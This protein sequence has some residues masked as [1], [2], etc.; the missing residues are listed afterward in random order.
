M[1][2][3][4]AT[5]GLRESATLFGLSAS[6]ARIGYWICVAIALYHIAAS[7][8][9]PSRLGFF[10]STQIQSAI[11]LGSAVLVVFLIRFPYEKRSTINTIFSVVLAAAA[12]VSLGVVIFDYDRIL[13][14]SLFGTLDPTGVILALCLVIPL[15]EALRRRTGWIL[16]I[17]I[18]LLVGVV[19]FQP[20][21]PGALN[22]RG[23]GYDRL[24]Y[25]AYVGSQ[26]IFGMP[27]RVAA[28]I[29]L[30]FIV[31]GALISA[32]GA[33]KWFLDIA[34]RLT[35]H[36]VGGPAKSAVVASALFGSISGSPSANAASTGVLTIPLMIRAGY[37]PKFAAAT[38]A[39]A[40]TSGQI[41]P[42]V[43]GA[44]AFVMAEW[45]GN[46][47]TAIVQAAAI[48]AILY[49]GIIYAS[50]HF[51]AR[52][53]QV[54]PVEEMTTTELSVL[55]RSGWYFLV[56]ILA[57]CLGLFVFRFPAQ[58]AAGVALPF[59]VLVS[60]LNKDRKLWL[61]PS[62]IA[63][64]LVS[65]I[66]SWK[67]LAIIS[68]AV[69]IMVGAMQLSG[70]GIKVS[71]FVIDLSGG[72]LVL[73]LVLVGFAALILGM[74]LDAIPSYITLATLLAPA[75]IA[76]GV[77]TVGAHLFV[78]YWGLASFF[79]PPLCIA[80]FITSGIAKS[81]VW[82]TGWEAMRLGLGAFLVPFA[83]VLEPALLL[84]GTVPE[85]V[86]A[87]LTALLGAVTLSAGIRGF[88][89]ARL[90]LLGRICMVVGGILMIAPG[91][92]LPLIGLTVTGVVLFAQFRRFEW[93]I[94]AMPGQGEPASRPEDRADAPIDAQHSRSGLP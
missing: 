81:D 49:I 23:Y 91:L 25:S 48:P 79:T 70:V 31:F 13:M 34:L 20:Y 65:S 51:H 88:A 54:A 14:Y 30:V 67:T 11:S 55:F 27:L 22:G 84:D 61:T 8:Q 78:V 93:S 64:S 19:I 12:L 21:M 38:E 45:T 80:V 62:R 41:L 33:G 87:A 68:G 66:D 94:E 89:L 15:L 17:L 71:D 7:V 16:P 2:E 85:I 75:L 47:Y 29:L 77:S 56:P 40:S 58:M 24:L 4:T 1:T 63:E 53:E 72:N 9:L 92:A 32:S 74:G 59:V 5:E 44:I 73:L 10:L 57:L 36:R 28:E 26:G 83:F 42:P 90:S 82:E 76:L 37:K 69:G 50:V 60:F 18:L 3:N 39:V 35:G 46:T 52:R 43:M 86:R 6:W